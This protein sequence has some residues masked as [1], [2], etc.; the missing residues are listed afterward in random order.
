MEL[1]PNE[2]DIVGGAAKVWLV[3]ADRLALGAKTFWPVELLFRT[4]GAAGLPVAT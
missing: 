4:I 3:A 2:G 1:V